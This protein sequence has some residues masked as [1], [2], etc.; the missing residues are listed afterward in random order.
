MDRSEQGGA[1]RGRGWGT[2]KVMTLRV[3]GKNLD[4]G[5]SLRTHVGTRI[6]FVIAKYSAGLTNG[7]V[8]IEREGSG[9]RTDCTLHLM[10]GTILQVEAGA[11]EA[12]ASFNMAA[13]RIEK[14][15][16]R[17]KSKMKDRTCANTHDLANGETAVATPVES[18]KSFSADAQYSGDASPV[19]IAESFDALKE[20]SVSD[21]VEQLDGP[22][23][24]VVIF[25]RAGDDRPNIVYRRA[26]GNIGW[27]DPALSPKAWVGA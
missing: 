8:T 26:D 14:Q 23:V 19:V 18:G 11:Q 9:F 3:S 15:L 24:H 25:R 16:R 13:E 12:Y 7:H 5:E 10:S 27:V 6:D 21:A 20:M 2:E 22:N 17:H 4:I 1:N